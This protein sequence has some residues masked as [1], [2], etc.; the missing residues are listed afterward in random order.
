VRGALCAVRERRW[1]Q[2]TE[3]R[4]MRANARA[5]RERLLA[6]AR[7]ALVRHG[8]DAS[9]EG[10][11][12]EAGVGIGTFYRHF[13]SREALLEAVLQ[14][15]FDALSARARDL[16]AAS[17]PGPALTA[18]LREFMEF[19]GAYR[20]LA[21]AL[22]RT[23][24]DTTTPLHAACEGMRTAGAALL[25][26]AQEAGAI[27]ADLDAVELFTIVSGLTWA[28]EQASTAVPGRASADRALILIL[29]G[30]NGPRPTTDP[31]QEP[32]QSN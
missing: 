8:T 24:H 4:A 26:R 16:S 23:L 18:W 3:A 1:S 6:H 29:E 30:L 28:E 21:A 19:T 2:M 17:S 5:N 22:L 7:A 10:I 20:G 27:R 31:P 15:R 14:E 25:A 12:R 9:L 32:R 11:A 13:P